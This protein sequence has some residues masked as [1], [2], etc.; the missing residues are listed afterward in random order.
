MSYINI[1]NTTNVT[2]DRIHFIINRQFIIEV[3]LEM[4]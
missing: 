1:V 4:A 2:F 3:H